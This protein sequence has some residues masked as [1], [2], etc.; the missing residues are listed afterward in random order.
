M[1]S[2]HLFLELRGISKARGFAARRASASVSLEAVASR[3]M[4]VVRGG[5]VRTRGGIKGDTVSGWVIRLEVRCFLR[6]RGEGR[7]IG[8]VCEQWMQ[9]AK[10]EIVEGLVGD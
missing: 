4:A 7:R 8:H 1:D 6:R 3:R 9:D 2:I 10:R 5:K